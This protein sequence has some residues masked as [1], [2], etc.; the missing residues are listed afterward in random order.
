MSFWDTQIAVGPGSMRREPSCPLCDNQLATLVRG[1]SVTT[2][3]HAATALLTREYQ[4]DYRRQ[5]LNPVA[6]CV[7]PIDK[8]FHISGRSSNGS[9]CTH[10][11]NSW[12]VPATRNRG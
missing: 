11:L 10:K 12:W 9:G 2:H 7:S 6:T 5:S 1:G 8:S 4:G 3:C